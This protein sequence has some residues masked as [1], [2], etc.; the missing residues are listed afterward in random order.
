VRTVPVTE[1]DRWQLEL[2][3]RMGAKVTAVSVG[4]P[5]DRAG[6]PLF[7]VI[8]AVNGKAVVSPTD[9]AR[10][11]AA[12]AAGEEV[13]LSYYFRGEATR[14]RVVLGNAADVAE[15]IDAPPSGEGAIKI[16]AAEARRIAELEREVADLKARVI[17]LEGALQRKEPKAPPEPDPHLKSP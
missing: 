3:L 10:R 5:A 14:R 1:R 4:S 7:A 15:V 12:L 2:P 6:I 13:E 17:R 16:G 8:V 11:I 9:L